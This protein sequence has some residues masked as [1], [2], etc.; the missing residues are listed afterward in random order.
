MLPLPVPR[1]GSIEALQSFLNLSNQNDFVLVVAWLLVSVDRAV[2]IRSSRSPPAH[3]AK[4]LSKPQALVDP[5]VAV[6]IVFPRDERELMIAANNGYVLAFDN[7][8]GLPSW[9]SEALCRLASGGSFAVRQLYTDDEEVLFAP[10]PLEWDR[11]YRW[12]LR[13]GRPR[14]FA[15]LGADWRGT[16]SFRDRALAGIRTCEARDPG[17]P[18]GCGGTRFKSCGFRS[19]R[20]P[21]MADFALWATAC[22]TGVW[23][24][25]TFTRAYAVNRKAAI[26]G[27]VDADPIAAC[28]REF[29]S[30]RSSWTGSA[31]RSS[32]G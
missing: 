1:G 23:P 4:R 20:L 30:E 13:F 32:A 26:E 6:V 10:Y 28:V 15:D 19:P 31:A 21:R 25:G 14:D 17:R 12:P 8:S 16:P 2:L 24:A 29:M 9:L 27:I 7:L 18:A 3:R 11:G 22:E 5:N